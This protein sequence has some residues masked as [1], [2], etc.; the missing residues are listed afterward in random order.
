MAYNDHFAVIGAAAPVG[1][2]SAVHHNAAA[3]PTLAADSVP[4]ADAAALQDTQAA[5]ASS[6]DTPAGLA[7]LPQSVKRKNN[8]MHKSGIGFDSLPTRCSV[9]SRELT[10]V[11][12]P[13]T[14][15]A[16]LTGL[17]KTTSFAELQ[18]NLHLKLHIPRTAT[19][20]F[21]DSVLA[22]F[23]MNNTLVVLL[24]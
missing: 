3:A 23:L 2:S 10:F 6:D 17:P 24:G 21:F 12:I 18:I 1:V 22:I 8:D 20:C 4:S 9:L 13:L 14:A 5:A 11:L 15:L 16:V 19:D 7:G